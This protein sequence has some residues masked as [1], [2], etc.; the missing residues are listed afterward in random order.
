MSILTGIKQF[1]PH[2]MKKIF[3][4]VGAFLISAA[5]IAQNA[6]Q[7]DPQKQERINKKGTRHQE[8]RVE[9]EVKKV[10]AKKENEQKIEK[11]TETE[12]S[13]EKIEKKTEA[14]PKN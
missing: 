14:V 10:P 7:I 2:N 12:K 4:S 5:L 11:S 9:K 6:P 8:K 1:K 13:S 3:L